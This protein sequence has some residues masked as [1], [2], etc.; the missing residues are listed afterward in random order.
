[1]KQLNRMPTYQEPLSQK[2]GAA[3]TTTRGWYQFFTGVLQGQATGLPAPQVV[4][5][6]PFAFVAPAGGTAILTGGTVS[7][8]TFSRDGETS[9]VT[10]QTSGMFPMSLGDILTITYSALP[11]L[12]F[13][14]R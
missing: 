6:S 1:M 5:I 3:Y 13:V 11:T 8:V 4:G 14:P 10:G 2:A 9:Y 7:N 12:I